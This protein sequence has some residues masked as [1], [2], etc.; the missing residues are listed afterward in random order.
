MNSEIQQPVPTP[1]APSYSVPWKFIDNWIGVGLLALIQGAL[2]I[3]MLRASRTDLAQTAAII[4][5]ELAYLLPVILILAWRHVNW[6]YLGFGRFEWSTLGIGCGLLVVAYGIII[7]HNL[8]LYFLGVDTQG[9]EIVKMFAELK[10]PV[11][12]FIVGAVV[13]PLVEEIFFRGFLFQGFRQKYGWIN[14]MLLSSAIFAAAHLDLVA[15]IP[16]FILGNLLAYVYHRSNSV[17]PGIILHF[18]VNA[19]GLCGAYFAAHYQNL[20]PL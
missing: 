10:S 8:V 3:I 1:E 15:L 19:F 11:W 7:V 13:A 16:T 20:I 9:N 17:W 2:F 18:L 14:A 12:F 5:L 6:K 4:L